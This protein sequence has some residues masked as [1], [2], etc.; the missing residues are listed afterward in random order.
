MRNL[1]PHLLPLVIWTLAF[2]AIYGPLLVGLQ[3]LPSSDTVDGMYPQAVALARAVHHGRL[4]L[5]SPGSYGGWPVA[6]DPQ[7][8]TFYPPR[9]I[10]VLLAPGGVLPVQGL[11]REALAHLWLAGAGMYLL[12]T[13]MSGRRE[14]GLLAAITW[15]LSG[16]LTGY[17]LH[18]LP[19]L[20][21]ISWLPWALLCLHRAAQAERPARWLAAAAAALALCALAGHPQTLMQ[22]AYLALAFFL[23][24]AW[25]ARW[26]WGAIA[27]WGACLVLL[28]AAMAA[29]LWLPVLDYYPLTA[30]A[31]VG[32]DYVRSGIPLQDAI[33]L[34]VPNSLTLWAPQYVGMGAL[35]LLCLAWLRRSALPEARRSQVI[36]WGAAALITGLLA[37]GDD[38]ILFALGYRLLPGLALFRQQERW[39]GPVS[40]CLTLLA[41]LGVDAWL[42][43]ALPAAWR[44]MRRVLMGVA[45]ALLL[46]GGMLT[47]IAA[48]GRAQWVPLWLWAW[49]LWGLC[50]LLLALPALTGERVGRPQALA[51]LTLLAVV[52]LGAV[53]TR[54]SGAVPAYTISH[55]AWRRVLQETG[56]ADTAAAAGRLDSS[57]LLTA[58]LG[59]LYGLEEIW[60]VSPLQPQAL[61]DLRSLPRERLY[62]LLDVGLTLSATPPGDPA[63]PWL[64]PLPQGS[65]WL[66]RGPLYL[67]VNP[68]WH[69]R[70]W[71]VQGVQPVPDAAA[72]LAALADPAL[73]PART[74]VLE[75]GPG[76]AAAGGGLV[77]NGGPAA[78]GARADGVEGRGRR[79]GLAGAQRVAVPRLAGQWLAGHAGRPAGAG[80][81]RQRGD[82][83]VG[84][85]G[86]GASGGA[87]LCRAGG[88]DRAGAGGI[89]PGGA[90]DDLLARRAAGLAP[91]GAGGRD[92]A[93]SGGRPGGSGC[94]G[95]PCCGGGATLGGGPRGLAAAELA[96][97]AGGS[98]G[99]GGRT[100][101][102]SSWHAGAARRRGLFG[103]DGPGLA[104]HHHPQPAG[105]RR[106]PLAAALSAGA[107]H[108]ERGGLG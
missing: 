106:S 5:W 51:L 7:A 47:V 21:T 63:I 16:Y 96:L 24:A 29:P 80:A 66:Q 33:Q 52:D 56:L 100:A 68:G 54:V 74:V 108:S 15:G 17:P 91:G 34:L 6:G 81:A 59:E 97:G 82:D 4:P 10:T 25:R 12:A 70:A 43:E 14:A 86:G 11:L 36:F 50:G 88:V 13:A 44:A 73:D 77:G 26:T 49:A 32:Y 20:E 57:Q 83:G 104:G 71:L 41:A 60:G 39:L 27:R 48:G 102:L 90:G 87:A 64:G 31:Q 101:P 58:N 105:Q 84:A 94:S 103:A 22:G 38:G 55:D 85:A 62:A 67:H 19:V 45:V 35:L 61:L 1:K 46:A 53:A 40:L 107:R 3:G 93:G 72:A 89:G 95:V 79:A 99:P 37:L 78:A 75:G 76:G 8:A 92:L 30:R 18:Q 65:L 9:W 28:S 2:L 69:A 23:H 98:V 42:G